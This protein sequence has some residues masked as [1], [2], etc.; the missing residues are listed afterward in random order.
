[1]VLYCERFLELAVDLLS[2]LSTRCFV[3]TLL[4]DR[5]VLIKC[6]MCPLGRHPAAHLFRQLTDQ[7]QF[8]SSFP[9]HDLTGDVYDE[10]AVMQVGRGPRQRCC[11]SS[12]LCWL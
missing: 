10:D 2:Q 5:A 9:I 3:R 1:M 6:R 12:R 11:F 7:L 4:E 8:Y